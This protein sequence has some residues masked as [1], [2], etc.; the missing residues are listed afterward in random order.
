MANA[1]EDLVATVRGREAFGRGLAL[2]RQEQW[3]EALVAF[4]QA[5]AARA[6]PVVDFNIAYCLRALGRYVSGN[7]PPR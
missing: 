6:A 5:A 2:A 3:G 7:H 1:V 4:E